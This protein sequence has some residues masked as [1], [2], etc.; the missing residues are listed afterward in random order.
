MHKDTREAVTDKRIIIA[1]MYADLKIKGQHC[2]MIWYKVNRIIHARV[3][4]HKKNAVITF[5]I[6]TT[7]M[8]AH[9]H[10]CM[11]MRMQTKRDTNQPM[12]TKLCPEIHVGWIH[13][14]LSLSLSFTHTPTD[15]L[16]S[17]K[18]QV[19]TP[20]D[21]RE[22]NRQLSL[23]LSLSLS[24]PLSVCHTHTHVHTYTQRRI[25]VSTRILMNAKLIKQL[26]H[27]A[28]TRACVHIHHDTHHRKK[29][30]SKHTYL[31]TNVLELIDNTHTYTTYIY[32]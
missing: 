21:A 18:I 31:L 3:P 26:T 14:S 2:D 16:T 17:K 32:M 23:S 11:H 5:Q 12:Y 24:P 29:N 4:R 25:Q 15:I 10:A 19:S 8:H 20:R 27:A 13:L 30:T 22:I 7:F 28:T 1:C 9:M 6:G